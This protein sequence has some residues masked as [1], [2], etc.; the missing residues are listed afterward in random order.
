MCG[1][2]PL[3]LQACG[4]GAGVC[5]FCSSFFC[6]FLLPAVMTLCFFLLSFPVSLSS[7]SPPLQCAFTPGMLLEQILGILD[8][9][10]T[11]KLEFEFYLIQVW[12]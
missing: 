9:C 12:L 7:P 3:A 8:Q 11:F 5:H 2:L 6:L 4:G 10:L 1:E